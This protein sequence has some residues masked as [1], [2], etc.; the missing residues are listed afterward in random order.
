[1]ETIWR[2]GDFRTVNLT[3]RSC[4]LPWSHPRKTKHIASHVATIFCNH[5]RAV[6]LFVPR[7]L[8]SCKVFTKDSRT[9]HKTQDIASHV[10]TIFCN[11]LA[12]LLQ[13]IVASA[14]GNSP[15]FPNESPTDLDNVIIILM[16][17]RCC[18]RQ[19]ANISDHVTWS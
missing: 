10:A 11:H 9:S 15:P 2:T 13:K 16:E 12:M 19:L 17:S 5:L 8:Q 4:M 3:F 14:V 7:V 1:M 18:S 6:S